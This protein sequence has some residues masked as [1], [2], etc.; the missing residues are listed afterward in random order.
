MRRFLLL[1]LAVTLPAP[2]LALSCMPHDPARTFQ[3]IDAAPETYIALHGTLTFDESLLPE[4]DMSNQQATPP[5]TRIPARIA[6]KAL[7]K[8]G[9]TV[10]FEGALTLIS[11]CFGPW[12]AQPPSGETVLAFIRQNEAGPTLSVDPCGGDAFFAPSPEK[13][14]TIRACFSGDECA[15]Q[16]P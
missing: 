16:Q 3:R 9:Y 7:G 6:G 14:E 10:P 13:L 2:A 4:V 11:K 12:C 15:A 8:D 5:E 1:A